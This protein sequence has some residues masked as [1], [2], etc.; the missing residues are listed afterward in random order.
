MGLGRGGGEWEGRGRVSIDLS[1]VWRR[2]GGGVTIGKADPSDFRLQILLDLVQF[3][4]LEAHNTLQ[5]GD[6]SLE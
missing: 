3:H 4:L 5:G 1:E 2:L 6:L